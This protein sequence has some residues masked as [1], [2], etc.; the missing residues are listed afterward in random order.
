MLDEDFAAYCTF[1]LNI[2]GKLTFSSDL[3]SLCRVETQEFVGH[4][5]FHPRSW[6]A[7][8]LF[9]RCSTMQ[10]FY[11]LKTLSHINIA[12]MLQKFRYTVLVFKAG[13]YW[14]VTF[15]YTK[16]NTSIL[17]KAHIQW[18]AEVER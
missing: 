13:V 9:T 15:Y 12:P 16:L 5:T 8:E 18:E 4:R 1:H 11:E 6:S 10:F 2:W 7:N 17:I 3:S 14:H